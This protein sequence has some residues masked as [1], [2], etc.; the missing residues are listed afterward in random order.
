M[1]TLADVAKEA[2]VSVMSASNVLRGK[3]SVSDSIRERVLAAAAKLDYRANMAAKSL[4]S[5]RTGMIG[6]SVPKLEMPFHAAF[7]SAVTTAAEAR[8]IR[9]VA[10]QTHSDPTA[11]LEI[12]RGATASLVD[13]TIA[14]TIG[15]SA[16]DIEN[17]SR[18]HA[19]VLFDEQIQRTRLDIIS[20]PNQ[21]GAR[22]AGEHLIAKGCR[23]IAVLGTHDTT[24]GLARIPG[25]GNDQR[26]VGI[27]GAA[28]DHPHVRLIPVPC[29]WDAE[30]A[31]TALVS[32]LATGARMDGVFALTDSIAL[33]ALR[34]LADRGLRCPQEVRVIGFDGIRE[35]EIAVPSLSTISIGIPT[36]A[37]TA[38]EMLLSRIGTS[39][40]TLPGRR[41]TPSYTL[42]ER[43]SSR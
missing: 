25:G 34:A 6:L 5:G 22:A 13:G 39:L 2:G 16:A 35:G 17:A 11:E 9:V 15:S 30:S 20:C 43:E 40:D 31:R 12:L 26:W 3:P 24:P 32:A 28:A 4:R 36:L 18:G 8:G 41:F 37:Q 19:V 10:Q 1:A 27:N 23:R 42:I 38:V 7:A 29:D 21:A 33:G 14:C